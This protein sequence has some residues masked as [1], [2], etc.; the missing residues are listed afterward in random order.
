MKVITFGRNDN[1]DVIIKDQYVGRN[2]CQI[3]E[4]E[5][6]FMVID[7]NSTNGTYVNGSRITGQQPLSTLDEVRIGQT[8]LNWQVYFTAPTTTAGPQAPIDAPAKGNKSKSKT[9][10][11]GCAALLIVIGGLIAYFVL[12]PYTKHASALPRNMV[13]LMSVNMR[14]LQKQAEINQNDLSRL[15]AKIEREVFNNRVDIDNSGIRLTASIY[16][17]VEDID[18]GSDNLSSGF[19]LPLSDQRLFKNFILNLIDDQRIILS[20]NNDI[21]YFSQDNVFVGFDQEK[22]LCYASTAMSG[23]Q[24]EDRG[25]ELLNQDISRSGK[26][27][28]LFSLLRNN[29]I[30][31]TIS[32]EECERVLN[33]VGEFR[34]LMSSIG[35]DISNT[36][37]TIQLIAQKN[38][39]EITL[40]NVDKKPISQNNIFNAI[41][42]TKLNDFSTEDIAFAAINVN[43]NNLLRE[44]FASLPANAKSE[45]SQF[46]EE[47]NRELIDLESIIRA[48]D[49]DVYLSIQDWPFNNNAYR[50]REPKFVFMAEMPSSGALNNSVLSVRNMVVNNY[51]LRSVMSNVD[52]DGSYLRIQSENSYQV[53]SHA[54]QQQYKKD[55]S[56]KFLY[57]SVNANPIIDELEGNRDFRELMP[58]VRYLKRVSTSASF[59]DI[60]LKTELT[61]TWQSILNNF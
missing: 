5:G 53:R 7:L 60:S 29:P 13:A 23:Y 46:F 42:G 28:K 58:Y 17:F 38:G 9:I 22:C 44:I 59:T 43:G 16:V 4:D 18:F 3:V 40:N 41:K 30:S 15:I 33:G 54:S 32:G 8:V 55:T 51:D 20:K 56:N 36:F 11:M 39:L 26:K 34:G 1:N 37:L 10:I 2:H 12:Q 35:V 21:Q 45:M 25:L 31:C 52:G 61:S 14:T 50:N 24:L 47:C 57:I 6:K 48:I 19:V 27:S 49:G